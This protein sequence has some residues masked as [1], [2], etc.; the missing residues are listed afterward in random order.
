VID[1]ATL[2]R[3]E[4]ASYVGQ[5][6]EDHG[7]AVVLSGGSCVSIYSNEN[8]VSFDLDLIDVGY[9]NRKHIAGALSTIGYV[10][11]GKGNRYFE[12]PDSAFS[13]EFPS[14]PLMIG[15]QVITG[16]GIDKLETKLGIIRL[17]SPTNCVKDRL[18]NYYY[19]ND[20]QCLHQ[21]RMVVQQQMVNANE[22]QLWLDSEG[23]ELLATELLKID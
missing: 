7:V 21:A 11:K 1:I 8:Y 13:L 18:A 3:Q 16:E 4:L 10:S 19:F 23:I 22:L 14:A 12:H 2:N 15:D 9:S 20:I 17:L 6:L 5:T